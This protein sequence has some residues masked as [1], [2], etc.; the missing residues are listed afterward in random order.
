M[1]HSTPNPKP[2]LLHVRKPLAPAT[3][4]LFSSILR[5]EKTN[6]EQALQVREWAGNLN[7]TPDMREKLD[8]EIDLA[9]QA[10]TAAQ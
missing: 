5:S 4:L 10:R 2:G 1:S 9:I 3:I 7:M 6:L 8:R